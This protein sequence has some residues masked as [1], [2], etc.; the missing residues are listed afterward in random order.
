M[1]TLMKTWAQTVMSS[2]KKK[3]MLLNYKE[4]DHG[5]LF[6]KEIFELRPKEW[7]FFRNWE[8]SISVHRNSIYNRPKEKKGLVSMRK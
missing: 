2:L 3:C 8:K 1:V 5:R 6:N 4:V 7:Y